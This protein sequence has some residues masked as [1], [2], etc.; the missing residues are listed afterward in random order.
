MLAKVLEELPRRDRALIGVALSRI[1]RRFAAR[2]LP[3]PLNDGQW[4]FERRLFEQD[5]VGRL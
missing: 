4:R 1:D 3:D 5:G 2:T